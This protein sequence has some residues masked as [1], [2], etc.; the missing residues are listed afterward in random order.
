MNSLAA[1]GS[2][3]CE[4]MLPDWLLAVLLKP[5]DGTLKNAPESVRARVKALEE[6]AAVLGEAS[7]EGIR[8]TLAPHNQK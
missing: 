3:K 7:A 5:F 6:A 2:A 4:A 8:E 1:M